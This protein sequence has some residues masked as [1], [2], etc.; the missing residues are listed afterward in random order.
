M[1]YD[2]DPLLPIVSEEINARTQA[3]AGLSAE[4]ESKLLQLND[5]QKKIISAA[6]KAVKSEFLK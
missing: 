6:D 1:E 3:F 5:D 2:N 4:E